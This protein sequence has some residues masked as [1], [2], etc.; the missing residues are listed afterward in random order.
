MVIYMVYYFSAT[1]NSK[2]AADVIAEKTGDIAVDIVDALK[3]GIEKLIQLG[4]NE[5]KQMGENG[6]KAV[7]EN[8]NY[9]VLAQRFIDVMEEA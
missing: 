7:M 1:G 8:F 4:D 2:H 5:L 6:R 3:N 9:T